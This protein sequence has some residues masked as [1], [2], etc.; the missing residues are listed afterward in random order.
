MEILKFVKIN[1]REKNIYFKSKKYLKWS[2]FIDVF[3]DM[4]GETPNI[5]W[6]VSGGSVQSLNGLNGAEE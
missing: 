1:G 6:G 3:G 5:E 2:D 4:A